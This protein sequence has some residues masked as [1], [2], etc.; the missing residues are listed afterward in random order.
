LKSG[1]G[2]SAPQS[3]DGSSLN[4][5][6]ETH[7]CNETAAHVRTDVASACT[8]GKEI[9]VLSRGVAGVQTIQNRSTAGMH[10]TTQVALIEFVGAF[11]PIEATFKI[12]MAEVDIAVQKNLADALAFIAGGPKALLLREPQRRVCC[13]DSGDAWIIQSCSP[14]S[15]EDFGPSG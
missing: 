14:S 1:N 15:G 8:N 3:D 5:V 11:V 10:C 4:I 9:Y 7:V 12:E 13:S 2:T 6:V